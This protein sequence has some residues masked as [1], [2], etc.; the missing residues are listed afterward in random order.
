MK[1]FAY[2]LETTGISIAEEHPVQIGY[3]IVDDEKP[4]DDL[5]VVEHYVN[6][7]REISDGAFKVHNITREMTKEGLTLEQF[8]QLIIDV[9]RDNRCEGVL[10]FNGLRFDIPL[11]INCCKTVGLDMSFL[12]DMTYQDP[13]SIYLAEN[14]FKVPRPTNREEFIRLH[15]RRTPKGEKYNREFLCEKYGIQVTDSHQAGD[16]ILVTVQLWNKLRSVAFKSI[17]TDRRF[18]IEQAKCGITGID[19]ECFVIYVGDEK[20]STSISTIISLMEEKNKP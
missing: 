18:S 17:N 4:L 11:T 5:K 13:S 9:I 20:I 3:C 14:I 8:G 15:Q 2:D 10:A 6:S 16:D 12:R 1:Y 7:D 19:C